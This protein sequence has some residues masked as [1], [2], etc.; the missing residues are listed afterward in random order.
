MELLALVAILVLSLA[1]TLVG[2]LCWTGR[3][4]GW[5]RVPTFLDALWPF[6]LWFGGVFS[7][8]MLGVVL[9]YIG[10]ELLDETSQLG[11][12]LLA[13]ASPLFLTVFLLLPLLLAAG[14]LLFIEDTYRKKPNG[15]RT[16]RLLLP[17]WYREE[18]QERVATTPDRQG[19]DRGRI[20]PPPIVISPPRERQRP[21]SPPP[22]GS[23]PPPPPSSGQPWTPPPSPSPPPPSPPGGHERG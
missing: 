21:S 10:G 1:W 5:L 23:T 9:G 17:R 8:T 4:R 7:L 2:W 6:G 18:L 19:A 15:T 13:I 20:P 16:A 12:V 14:N 22:P 3:W 11:S